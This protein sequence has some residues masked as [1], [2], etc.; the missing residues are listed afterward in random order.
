[1]NKKLDDASIED[2]VKALYDSNPQREWQRSERHRTEFA[3]TKR[4][5]ADYLP[6]PPA[7]ILDCGG[8][9]GYYAITLTQ[10]GYKVTLFDLSPELL[11]LAQKKAAEVVIELDGYVQGT[12]TD[13]SR[14]ADNTFDAVLLMGPLYHLLDSGD[15]LLALREAYRVVKPGAPVFAAFIS[16]YAGHRDA[17]AHYPENA[18]ENPGI[19]NTIAETGHLPP[20]EDGQVGFTAYFAHPSEIAPMCYEAGFE[21][22]THL[23]LEGVVSMQE[24]KINTLVD[25]AWRFWVDINYAIAHD[26]TILGGVEHI[27]AIC[28]KPRWRYALK[29]IASILHQNHIPFKVVGSTSL[30]LR[31]IQIPVND[32]DLEMKGEDIYRFE[33]LF[34]ESVVDPV[35]LHESEQ[36][37]ST[38]GRFVIHGVN[39]EVMADLY[40]RVGQQWVPSFL[41]TESTVLMDHTAVPVLELEEEVLAYIRRGHLERV[42]FALPHCKADRLVAL[43]REAVRKGML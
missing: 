34:R 30:A 29:E 28:I 1:M 18:F 2:A 31:G 40:R 39:V 20:R 24:E 12:A 10:Q 23:G 36:W 38:I 16:R 4:A 33:N 5:L 43:L 25:D 7:C 19:Y 15:R 35:Q 32:L 22:A 41:S 8:G 14:F 26:S 9:P 21:V 37:R 3:V 11:A 17:A 42:A 13:L 6:P 27:L